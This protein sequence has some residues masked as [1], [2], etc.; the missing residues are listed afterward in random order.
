M[1]Q[2]ESSDAFIGFLMP[3]YYSVLL[4]LLLLLLELMIN[5][6]GIQA[7]LPPPPIKPH[8]PVLLSRGLWETQITVSSTTATF[9][10]VMMID[11]GLRAAIAEDGFSVNDNTN[12]DAPPE[13]MND[14]AS[15]ERL[16][17]DELD[18]ALYKMGINLE[19]HG[20]AK[21]I[22][23]LVQALGLGNKSKRTI[24]PRRSMLLDDDSNEEE[25]TKILADELEPRQEAV[26]VATG[27]GISDR[28]HCVPPKGLTAI[29]KEHTEAILSTRSEEVV[30]GSSSSSNRSSSSSSS[31]LDK[32]LARERTTVDILLR[33]DI[34]FTT[35]DGSEVDAYIVSTKRAAREWE[36]EFKDRDETH[37]VI[38]MSDSFGYKDPNT[39]AVADEVAFICDTVVAVPDLFRGQPWIG[40]STKDHHHAPADYESWRVNCTNEER[41]IADAASCAL[42][43]QA[44][45]QPASVGIFGMCYGG[46]RALELAAIAAKERNELLLSSSN[47]KTQE[48]T[49]PKCITNPAN[50]RNSSKSLFAKAAPDC[51]VVF[52]PTWYDP[53]MV[54]THMAC[55]IMAMFA[56]ND[57]LPG[58]RPEDATK[59]QEGLEANP[60]VIDY[61]LRSFEGEDN[62]FAHRGVTVSNNNNSK[63]AATIAD[64]TMLLATVWFDLYLQKKKK[65]TGIPVRLGLESSLGLSS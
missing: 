46:G 14:V 24:P 26:P 16:S 21:K 41:A 19:G 32:R 37:V 4:P 17:V 63:D 34:K 39:R 64:D 12:D 40:N 20:R 48:I 1:G 47:D 35:A 18:E 52:Y 65:T 9:N 57:K 62:G 59:L 56:A 29:D 11:G 44:E 45:Y 43:M 31:E 55:P 23:T 7:F 8:N 6:G 42:Y 5:E 33:Q 54:S 25:A 13:I 30:Q 28:R 51:V 60:Q 15:I 38:V 27:D 10:R 36:G 58:A 50:N 2:Q 53:K 49:Q 22:I 61:L 3:S